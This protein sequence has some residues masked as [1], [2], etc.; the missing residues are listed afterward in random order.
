M[1]IRT[2]MCHVLLSSGTLSC[3]HESADVR[4]LDNR[5]DYQAVDPE[6][7]SVTLTAAVAEEGA[8]APVR[9]P[10][11]VAQVWLHAHETSQHEYFWGAWL[12][13]VVAGEEWGY[14][15]QLT[16]PDAPALK[17]SGGKGP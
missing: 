1:K 8:A 10:P 6:A 9:L 15:P 2:A 14:R 13:V 7:Q 16:V 11:K 17:P 5:A 4:M 12:S 3:A